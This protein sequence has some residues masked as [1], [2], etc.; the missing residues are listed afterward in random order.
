MFI[1]ERDP[2]KNYINSSSI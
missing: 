1:K 2:L